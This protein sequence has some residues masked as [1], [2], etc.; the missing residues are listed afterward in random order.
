MLIANLRVLIVYT[1]VY[2]GRGSKYCIETCYEFMNK[3]FFF[4]VYHEPAWLY[5]ISYHFNVISQPNSRSQPLG[6]LKA[7]P[8]MCSLFFLNVSSS[9][10]DSV[11]TIFTL[12]ANL[13]HSKFAPF[14]KPIDVISILA[15]GIFLLRDIEYP[16]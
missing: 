4:L 16:A 14:K 13:C 11:A 7:V 3:L 8:K 9:S 15:H 1:S 2:N 6:A 12:R 10:R 5:N